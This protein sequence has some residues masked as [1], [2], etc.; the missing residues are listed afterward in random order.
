MPYLAASSLGADETTGST[1]G[2]EVLNRVDLRTQQ[3]LAGQRRAE[4]RWKWQ[5]IAAVAGAVFAAVRLG[6]I[7]VPHVRARR[8]QRL[9]QLGE[10][11]PNPARRRRRRR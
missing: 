4:A 3:I 5:T 10:A 8:Q 7:A 2:L 1:V 9:G 6:I 11:T